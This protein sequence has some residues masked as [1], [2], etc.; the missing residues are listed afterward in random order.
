VLSPVIGEDF[1]IVSI[2]RSGRGKHDG[3]VEVAD[4]AAD[5]T[6]SIDTCLCP[7]R[8]N[9]QRQQHVGHLDKQQ[10]V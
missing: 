7:S 5:R 9:L 10:T 2:Q 3:G 6:R 1:F 8:T 4:D